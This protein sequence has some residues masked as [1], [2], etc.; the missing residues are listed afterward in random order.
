MAKTK[1]KTKVAAGVQN[2]II[3]SRASYLYQAAKYLTSC[4]NAVQDG[5]STADAPVRAS[6][7]TDKQHKA[8]I[9]VS[10]QA[11]ADMRAVSLKAQIRQSPALKRTI[12]KFCDTLL[13]EGQTSHSSIEN[14]SRGGRKP[15]A[16][17][18]V[19]ACKTC[20]NSKRYPVDAPRQRRKALRSG[21]QKVVDAEQGG[22]APEG[23][24]AT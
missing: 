3:Y 16:D 20:G 21:E 14:P 4:A 2:R 13:V 15:W 10:R 6:T 24:E 1:A 17:V 23:E 22:V 18:L 7:K 11:V 8:I 5:P 9:N 19:I 12:C